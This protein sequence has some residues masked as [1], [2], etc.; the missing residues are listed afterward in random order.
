MPSSRTI[1]VPVSL[2]ATAL[3]AAA[4]LATVLPAVSSLAA[5]PLHAQQV[6]R[7]TIELPAE[8]VT[9]TR[10]P[11]R[12]RNATASAT[13]LDGA[14]L[15]A[16]GVTTLAEALRRVPGLALARTSS[17]G[18]PTSLFLRGGQSNYVRVL[19]DGVPL[20]EPGG[21]LDLGR[22]SLDDIERI[23]VLR[24]P[25]SVLYGSEAVT[26][27]IQLFTRRG[28]ATRTGRL[29]VGG[30]SFG[31]RRGLGAVSGGLGPVT[32]TLHGEHT[33]SDGFLPFNNQYRSELLLATLAAGQGT[34]TDARLTARHQTSTYR[35]PTGSGGALEDRNAAR[36]E[37]RVL[38]GLDLGHR[39]SERNETRLNLTTSELHPRTRDGSDD[40]A[41]TLG[42]YGYYASGIV[43]RRSADLRQVLRL[44][45]ATLALGG[46]WS[47]ETERSAS[48][49]LSE[50]GDFPDE[51]RAARETRALYAQGLG[52][53]GRFSYSTGLRLDENSAFGTFR[54]ARLG[55]AWRLAGATRLRAS[56]GNAF[57]A[58]SFF[59]NFA[60]GFTVG[61]PAL[62]PERARSADL[63]VE[64][65]VANI[66]LLKV[67][68]FAQRF[69]DLIQY[70]GAP[71]AFGDPNYYNIA[72]ANAGGVEFELTLPDAR[73]IAVDVGYTWTETRVVDSGFDTGSSASFVEGEALIRRPRHVVTLGLVRSL[74]SFGSLSARASRI[75]ERSDRDFS[76]FPATPVTMPAYTLVDLGA[77]LSPGFIRERGVGLQL[78]IE[79]ATNARI[80]QVAGFATPG[81][82]LYAGLKLQR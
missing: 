5:P 73:G 56:V 46:E 6:S 33:A 34:A 18:S 43:V 14:A 1:H 75:G 80:E 19:I 7:D 66:A 36:T 3:A 51:F 31:N 48:V 82:T 78:R 61:N 55:A 53:A 52:D 21:V 35:Y 41:D 28:T 15:R 65:V 57:K 42:F 25:A 49:S 27:V 54:T 12:S 79:N 50:F 59:E 8:V 20:N 44:G 70:T 29:E 77:V 26:G 16:E 23:E 30:G 39:W 60:T 63:G 45:G 64:T 10:E 68:A 62:R 81:R 17:F 76:G 40:A 37:R 58:P 71:P 22:V 9:A 24:G 47:R 74:G 72:A 67:T 32:A 4:L 13:V 69:R 2:R 38:A 11:G